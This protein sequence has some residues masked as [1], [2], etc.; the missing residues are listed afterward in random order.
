MKFVSVWSSLGFF[1]RCEF[2]NAALFFRKS[3]ILLN[4]QKTQHFPMY[5]FFFNKEVNRLKTS[6]TEMNDTLIY[7][8]LT[9]FEL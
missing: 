5:I 9:F 3:L 4:I 8:F 2:I 1:S 7:E 6:K